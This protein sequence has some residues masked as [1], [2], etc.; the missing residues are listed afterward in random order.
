MAALTRK[1]LVTALITK[2]NFEKKEAMQFVKSFYDELVLAFLQGE[3]VHLS[4]FGN[5]DI[6]D[7]NARP[8]RNPKTQE[9][10]L[11][12]PRRVV[13]FCAG[14]KLRTRLKET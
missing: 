11:I 4:G 9:S 3:S 5:F 14:K 6:K 10:A 12:A 7:K 1:E 8:G 13:T 2:L